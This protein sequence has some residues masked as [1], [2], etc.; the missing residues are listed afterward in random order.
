MSEE[1]YQVRTAAKVPNYAVESDCCDAPPVLRVRVERGRTPIPP[2]VYIVCDDPEH[3]LWANN[4]C[5]GY[6][7]QIGGCHQ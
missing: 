5:W 4:C 2:H 3:W 6:V 1:T 7:E